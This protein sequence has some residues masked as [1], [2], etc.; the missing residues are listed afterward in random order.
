M[1]QGVRF[2]THGDDSP[3]CTP[4]LA[5]YEG[6]TF[7]PNPSLIVEHMD[8]D[9]LVGVMTSTT[10]VDGSGHTTSDDTTAGNG[11]SGEV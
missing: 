4:T 7:S 5:E 2:S 11:N 8:D 9:L 6:R 10:A 3:S 1:P